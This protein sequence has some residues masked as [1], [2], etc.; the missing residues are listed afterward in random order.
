MRLLGVFV[1]TVLIRVYQRTGRP[2]M[3]LIGA[4][5]IYYPSCSDYTLRA[6]QKYGLIRGSWKGFCRICRCT[7]FHRGGVDEP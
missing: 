3:K 4:N 6:I 1:G 7:P 2:L 5:C